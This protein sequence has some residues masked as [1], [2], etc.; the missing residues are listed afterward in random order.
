MSTAFWIWLYLVVGK[1]ASPGPIVLL[2]CLAAMAGF[3]IFMH[4]SIDEPSNAEKIFSS[5]VH[6]GKKVGVVIVV[7]ILINLLYPTKNDL[8]LIFGGSLALDLAQTEEAQK[9][10]ENTLKAINTFLEAVAD[11]DQTK[12]KAQ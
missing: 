12:E 5:S 2:C 6:I 8:A 4:L 1:L 10:P 7:L 9:I 3:C 11:Q